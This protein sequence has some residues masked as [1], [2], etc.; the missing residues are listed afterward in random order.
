MFLEE[1]HDES[2]ALVKGPTQGG[3]GDPIQLS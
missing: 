3:V 2:P 1:L